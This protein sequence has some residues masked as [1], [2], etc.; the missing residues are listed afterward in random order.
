MK[1]KKNKE[2]VIYKLYEPILQNCKKQIRAT[3][4]NTPQQPRSIQFDADKWTRPSARHIYK[5]DDFACKLLEEERLFLRTTTNFCN[6][7]ICLFSN[8]LA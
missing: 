1:N 7:Q 3:K 6:R 5:C 4:N 2:K 8:N